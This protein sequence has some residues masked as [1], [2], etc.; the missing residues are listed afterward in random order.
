MLTSSLAL[1]INGLLHA[2]QLVHKAFQVF[3]LLPAQLLTVH[4]KS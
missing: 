3:V 4:H 2:R 1:V